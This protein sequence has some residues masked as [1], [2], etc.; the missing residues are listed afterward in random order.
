MIFYFG[1]GTVPLEPV[2]I[3]F[4]NCLIVLFILD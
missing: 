3:G 4:L 1:Q 2:I